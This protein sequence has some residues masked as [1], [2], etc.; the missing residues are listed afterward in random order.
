MLT[1]S[2]IRRWKLPHVLAAEGVRGSARCTIQDLLTERLILSVIILN[3][4]LLI[5]LGLIFDNVV[6]LGE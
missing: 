2:I 5:Q 6:R 3:V 4:L 1:V